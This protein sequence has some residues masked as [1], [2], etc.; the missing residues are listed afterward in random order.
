MDKSNIHLLYGNILET[1]SIEGT[2]EEK[3]SFTGRI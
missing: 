3:K 1:I 2:T